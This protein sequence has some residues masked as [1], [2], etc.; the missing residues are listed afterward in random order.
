M[1]KVL[2]T[3][4]AGF[5]GSHIVD[6]L[7][8]L[9]HQVVVIDDLS[10]G[11]LDNLSDH[12]RFFQQ[13]ICDQEAHHTIRKFVPDIIVHA[14]AQI[15]VS[16]SMIN[17]VKDI[18]V[19]LAGLLNIL[20]ACPQDKL[21]YFLF[22]STGGAIYG[23][24]KTIPADESHPIQPASVYAQSKYCSELYLDLWQRVYGLTYGS[25]RLA[26]VYG[27]RQNPHGEAGV[28]AI[29]SK[30]LLAG[31]QPK[32]FG[33]GEFTRDYVYVEDVVA[34]VEL[35]IHKQDQGIYNIGTGLETSVNELYKQV[36]SALNSDLQPIYAEQRPGE[37]TRSSISSQKIQNHLH[38]QAKVSF[39]EGIKETVAWF[40]NTY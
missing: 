31:E 7:I 33:T 12:A 13:S 25:L 11:N 9:D 19:N 17:P 3:G 15:S 36:A 23:E 16:D 38:W 34:A 21:P 26:N 20:N 24:Q 30:K 32:I 35:M 39:A 10:T 4:G 22:I 2:V 18:D 8:E 29:F 40:K 28:V 5:I 37:L 14:A 6:R 27:P 1:A